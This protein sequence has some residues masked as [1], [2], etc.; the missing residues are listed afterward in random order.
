[1]SDADII[2]RIA[3]GI[4]S[5]D[6]RAWDRLAGAANPFVSHAFLSALEDSGSVGRGTGWQPL[7]IVIDGPGGLAGALPA[8]GK[9][10]S[11]GEYVFDQG[12]AQAYE[13]AGGHYYPK[14]QIAV[15]FSPV[16]GPRVLAQDPASAH[17][18]IAAAEA[19]VRQNGLSSAHAT[20]VSPEQLGLFEDAGWLIRSDSQYHWANRDYRDFDDFLGALASRKRKAIRKERA[21]ALAGIEIVQLQGRAITEADWDA[22]WVF[23]QDTGARKWGR[24]YLTRDFFSLLAERMG[25]RLLLMFARRGGR[26]IAGALNLIGADTLYGR[27]WGCTEEVPF[28]H[29]ELC[30]YQAIEAAIARKLA[31]VEAG[32]QGDHKLARGYEPVATWSAHYI[33]D[34]GFRGAVSDFLRREREAVAHDIAALTEMGPFKRSG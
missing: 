9:S 20:F 8:Y 1:M 19:L 26:A 13:G 5:I 2:A 21:A 33:A 24:P 6:A 30:Y 7:P 31:R 4:A 3:P 29:F 11:Q 17:A 10:H 15:P 16:P 28:L 25:D 27:Y 32:A 18:L 34:K 22:F 23:Y 14:L 12:W